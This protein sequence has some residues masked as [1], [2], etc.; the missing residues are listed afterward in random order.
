MSNIVTKAFAEHYKNMTDW[1]N[2]QV[3][4]LSD[5][6][7][8][9]AP[10]PNLN[11]GVWLLGHL[12]VSDDDLGVMLGKGNRLFPELFPT[13][14]MNSPCLD[15][16]SYPPASELKKLWKQVYERNIQLLTDLSDEELEE[17]HA[18]VKDPETDFFKTKKKVV[19]FWILHQQYHAGQLGL[20]NAKIVKERPQTEGKPE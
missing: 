3:E 8:K 11:H 19:S 6:E 20:L 12:V 1:V 17:P 4:D 9:Q 15:P 10:A 7:L 13:F 5:E 14:G 2:W 16:N 18:R